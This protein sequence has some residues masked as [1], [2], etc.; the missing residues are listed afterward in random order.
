MT[1]TSYSLQKVDDL[2]LG[3]FTQ[4]VKNESVTRVALSCDETKLAAISDETK[5]Q[6][7]ILNIKTGKTVLC[8]DEI[9]SKQIVS[10][11]WK[12]KEDE[13]F[14][15]DE[16]GC[17]WVLYVSSS[18]TLNFFREKYAMVGQLDSKVIQVEAC[19][20]LLLASTL[21][22]TYMLNLYQKSQWQMGTKLREAECGACFFWPDP[23][24]QKLQRNGRL[25][26]ARVFCTRPGSRLWDCDL[27]GTVRQTHQLR[28]LVESH[29]NHF[30]HGFTLLYQASDDLLLTFNDTH[31]Y[32][33]DPVAV[34][35]VSCIQVDK[36]KFI[37]VNTVSGSIYALTN[38]GKIHHWDILSH[39]SI[40]ASEDALE[41]KSWK[42]SESDSIS[43]EVSSKSPKELAQF[44]FPNSEVTTWREFFEESLGLGNEDNVEPKGSEDTLH[45]PTDTS[46]LAYSMVGSE[47]ALNYFPLGEDALDE[48]KSLMAGGLHS[49]QEMIRSKLKKFLKAKAEDKHGEEDPVL[50]GPMWTKL[51][52]D[53]KSIF[54]EVVEK[55][56]ILLLLSESMQ[57]DSLDLEAVLRG[58]LASATNAIKKVNTIAVPSLDM[59]IPIHSFSC[60]LSSDDRR[61]LSQVLILM[62]LHPG[63][64]CHSSPCVPPFECMTVPYEEGHPFVLIQDQLNIFFEPDILLDFI[65]QE[66]Q[67]KPCQRFLLWILALRGSR[68]WST[69][70][71]IDDI[72]GA[73]DLLKTFGLSRSHLLGFLDSSIQEFPSLWKECREILEPIDC[74]FLLLKSSFDPHTW[75]TIFMAFI[76]DS[77]FVIDCWQFPELPFFSLHS[78]ILEHGSHEPSCRCGAPLPCQENSEP[79]YQQVFLKLL[80]LASVDTR[81][82]L[83]EVVL[84]KKSWWF[85]IHLKGS[86][87]LQSEDGKRM[88]LSFLNW[89][90]LHLFLA[91]LSA[92]RK[93][94]ILQSVFEMDPNKCYACGVEDGRKRTAS[95]W[96][97]AVSLLLNMFSA[98]EVVSMLRKSCHRI[99]PGSIP[100]RLYQE[101]LYRLLIGKKIPEAENS[102]SSLFHLANS[103]GKPISTMKAH[104]QLYKGIA[105]GEKLELTYGH[106]WGVKVRRDQDCPSC[107]LPLWNKALMEEGILIYACGHGM[108]RICLSRSHPH[109]TVCLTCLSHS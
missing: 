21:T 16:T 35:I 34:T 54:N 69:E 27:N 67:L 59:E 24:H 109:P 18:K 33:I 8:C 4:K 22:R 62:C 61:I 86:S 49:G 79:S 94:N 96:T 45:V 72:S 92:E 26:N 37:S 6:I 50:T 95:F 91:P 30:P 28:S 12:G 87:L 2:A 78:L 38:T 98:A 73:V 66:A 108:H 60:L 15:G 52:P 23:C 93:S 20:S 104:P 51:P 14:L 68:R 40:D 36:G 81:D 46:M 31:I 74:L 44:F 29:C 85:Y 1:W 13:L 75:N 90:I 57:K 41:V 103:T 105:A 55:G 9:R 10:V 106:H 39:P 48:L 83:S 101:L 89:P 58:W 71:R 70:T 88:L 84:G 77:E 17:V 3:T 42:K 102:V 82:Y 5:T 25:Q 76:S 47:Y 99:P 32:L 80:D 19:G 65:S 63:F 53:A 56:K 64:I 107:F 97:E 43:K 100:L 11:S 7:T